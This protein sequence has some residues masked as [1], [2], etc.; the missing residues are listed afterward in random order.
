MGSVE[1]ALVSC[2]I[3]NLLG[4]KKLDQRLHN[5]LDISAKRAGMGITYPINTANEFYLASLGCCEQLMG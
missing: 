5:L 2:F 4:Q 1:E 3:P